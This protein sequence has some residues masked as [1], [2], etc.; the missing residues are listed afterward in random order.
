MKKL[1][2]LAFAALLLTT[3]L[4]AQDHP[5]PPVQSRTISTSVDGARYEI[6]TSGDTEHKCYRLDKYTGTVWMFYNISGHSELQRE[7]SDQ[8][9]QEEGKINYQLYVLGDGSNA[10]LLNLNTG[11]IWY[12]EWHLFKS[13]EF[14]LQ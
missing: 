7:A 13:D 5:Q 1:L 3:T 6:V 10:Y 12:Y 2:T 8:D 11:I 9:I 14:R 4:S